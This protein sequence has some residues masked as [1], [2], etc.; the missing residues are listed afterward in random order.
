[1]EGRNRNIL[2][3]LTALVIAVAIFSSFGLGL[4]SGPTATITLP[5]AAPAE[6]VSPGQSG[7][8]GGVRVEVTPA[9]VQS[10]IAAM[11]RLESYSRIVTVTLE[12]ATST[13][14][15]WEDNGW[16]RCDLT[17]PT[18][19]TIHTIVG[20]GTVYRW[21]NEDE[22]TFTWPAGGNAVDVDGQRIPTYEDV[23]ALDIDRI[24]AA[25]YEN[26]NGFPCIYVEVAVPELAQVERY[27]VSSDT[28]LLMAAETE[29]NGVVVYSV[30]AAA[31]EIP[32]P[33]WAS[34]Q[35]PDG[36]VL[37]TVGD[38]GVARTL[39]QEHKPQRDE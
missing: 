38:K 13:A 33:A 12:G 10:V 11:S 39:Q 32:A 36:T 30:T 4:F 22:E 35:L 9:T 29:T 2:V 19:Q 34:F 27:W 1:M 25:G 24:T 20:G 21:N 7:E 14:L 18:G 5:T 23:L 6:S 28:G 16:N 8:S 26:K 37:H 17:L 3:A 31:A 15:V